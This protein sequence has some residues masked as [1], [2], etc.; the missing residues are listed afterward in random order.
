VKLNVAICHHTLAAMSGG[1]RVLA[2]LIEAL[3]EAAYA[4]MFTQL[5][6]F[7]KNISTVSTVKI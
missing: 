1:E 4:Q 7:P 2:S 3:N 6:Q 5:P